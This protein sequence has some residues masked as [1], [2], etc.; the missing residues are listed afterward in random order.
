MTR[1]K[2]NKRLLAGCLVGA[3]VFGG[4]FFAYQELLL[5]GI[6][7]LP[8]KPCKGAVERSTASDILPSAREVEES[9]RQRI[10]DGTYYFH[11]NLTTSSGSILS[12]TVNTRDVTTTSWEKYYRNQQDGEP[13]RISKNNIA[14]LSWPRETITYMPCTPIGAKK[15]EAS[16]GYSL[17]VEVMIVGEAKEPGTIL[18]HNLNEFA[19]QAANYAKR[20]AQCQL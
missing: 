19:F 6:E 1:N 7:D 4:A 15:S 9:S 11:C 12:A 17:V 13:S 2:I 10:E 8:G 16:Q 3:A 20:T 5:S 18:R 14:A